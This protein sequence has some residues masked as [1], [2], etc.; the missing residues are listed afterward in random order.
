MA[1]TESGYP[2]QHNHNMDNVSAFPSRANN[3]YSLPEIE[4]NNRDYN[5]NYYI[6]AREN[7]ENGVYL[8]EI[9]EMYHDVLGRPLPRF[10][11]NEVQAMLDGGIQADMIC[12]VL[13]YTGGAPRPSWAYARAVIQ[14]QAAMGAR[15]AADFNGNVAQ[16]R[17]KKAAPPAPFG[18][19]KRVVEQ[20]YAQRRYDPAELDAIPE[21]LLSMMR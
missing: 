8:S 13:A 3:L 18:G 14:K 16:W 4:N 21:E 17:E 12:A 9:G 15:T 2:Q 10:V 20:Q 6:R 11:A 1:I 19:G 7:T 5:N